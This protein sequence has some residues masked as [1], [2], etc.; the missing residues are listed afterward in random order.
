MLKKTISIV[1]PCFNE[2]N[3]IE[4]TYKEITKVTKSE[5]HYSFDYIFVDDGSVDNTFFKIKELATK[6]LKVKCIKLSRNF[7]SHISISAGFEHVLKSDAA[8]LIT[9]DL[10]EPPDIISKLIRKWEN[11][12]DIVWT[13]RKFRNQSIL[14]NIITT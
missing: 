9:S 1:I 2:E 4:N 11:G 8:I 13:V 10:Q 6:D 12:T 3:N 7:G 5:V 14:M